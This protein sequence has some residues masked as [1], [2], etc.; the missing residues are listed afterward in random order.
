[1]DQSQE[2]AGNDTYTLVELL[3]H[4]HDWHE[5]SGFLLI[6][7]TQVEQ[8]TLIL[9]KERK[10]NYFH[11]FFT[12]ELGVEQ[13]SEQAGVQWKPIDELWVRQH[14]GRLYHAAQVERMIVRHFPAYQPGVQLWSKDD[15]ESNR[16]KEA[17]CVGRL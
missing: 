12:Y 15:G 8:F 16:K 3:R 7:R 14:N 9:R 6:A 13:E 11:S 1:M 10:N 4:S 5:T 17:R 2:V